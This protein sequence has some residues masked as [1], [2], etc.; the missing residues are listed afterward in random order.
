M[1]A[2]M[3]GWQ[4][5]SQFSSAARLKVCKR[6]LSESVELARLGIPFNGLIE[7]RGLELLEPSAKLLELISGQIRD[8]SLDIFQCRHGESSPASNWSPIYMA[9]VSLETAR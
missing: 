2:R 1:P 9:A 3:M 4:S 7:M 6:L 8:G 5:A